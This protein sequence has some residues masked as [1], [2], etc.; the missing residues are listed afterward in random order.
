MVNPL[1]AHGLG[2]WAT[3]LVL[4][5]VA[6]PLRYLLTLGVT[7]RVVH[8]LRSRG[9]IPPI[10]EE[11]KLRNLARQGAEISRARIQESR[12][13]LHRRIQTSRQKLRRRKP[14]KPHP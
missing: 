6:A 8:L 11:D 3:V 2:V 14:K 13:N 10:A 5:K 12:A 9:T 4:Y 7:R 1:L